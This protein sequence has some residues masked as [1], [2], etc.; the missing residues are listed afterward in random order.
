MNPPVVDFL[1]LDLTN[2]TRCRGTDPSLEGEPGQLPENLERF[3]ADR[4]EARAGK[5]PGCC[6][7]EERRSCC[8]PEDKAACCGGVDE[9]CGCR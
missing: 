6:P 5:A 4:D 1:I 9:G 3:V 7:P 8:E 2:S